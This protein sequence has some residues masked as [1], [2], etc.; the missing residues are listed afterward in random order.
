MYKGIVFD[1]LNQNHK[2]CSCLL[3]PAA[4]AEQRGDSVVGHLVAGQA[5]VP[6]L[7][8]MMM[9]VRMMMMMMMRLG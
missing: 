4:G 3:Q 2:Y 6:H 7:M 1:Q 5:L 8:M 9:M